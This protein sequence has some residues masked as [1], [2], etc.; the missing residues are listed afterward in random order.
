[1]LAGPPD[2]T[3]RESGR[4]RGGRGEHSGREAAGASAGAPSRSWDSLPDARPTSD[5]VAAR[6]AGHKRP[7]LGWRARARCRQ[8]PRAEDLPSELRTAS[9]PR[10]LARLSGKA[11]A[12]AGSSSSG[13]VRWGASTLGFFV[14][15][16]NMSTP[17]SA[18]GLFGSCSDRSQVVRYLSVEIGTDASTSN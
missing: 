5:V 15:S 12:G 7:P 17:G 1:M 13:S 18:H 3:S 9:R 10:P 11:V 2:S 14:M 8:K 4:G 6:Q 16:G